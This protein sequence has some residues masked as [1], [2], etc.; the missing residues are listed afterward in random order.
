MF[1]ELCSNNF[2]FC[3]CDCIL[4]QTIITV[5]RFLII[6][7]QKLSDMCEVKAVLVI[8][9]FTTST[10]FLHISVQY[11]VKMKPH[12][13]IKSQ[14]PCENE[15]K[16]Y[17]SNGGEF[18]YINEE[19]FAGCNCTSLYEAKRIENYMWWDYFGFLDLKRGKTFKSNSDM[20]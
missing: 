2:Y 8:K 1:S 19:V 15:Y 14:G 17:C 11:R 20:L 5:F 12:S 10:K 18:Y 9:I 6:F 7:F 4:R 3:Y 13:K 16:K